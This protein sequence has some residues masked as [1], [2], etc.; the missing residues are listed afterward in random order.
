VS[1]LHAESVR[2]AFTLQ[3]ESFNVSGPATDAP[4]IDAIVELA[5]PAAHERWLEAAC[6]PGLVSRRLAPH[7]AAVSGYDLTP[8]M[9]DVARREAARSGLAN[10]CFALGDATALPEPDGAFDGAVTRFSLHHIPL[11]GRVLAEL[12]RAVAPN[13]RIVI[14]D[15]LLDEDP[16]AAA[17][18]QELERLRDPSHWASLT[19]RRAVALADAAGLV[20]DRE[21]LLPMEL[22]FDDWVRRGAAGDGAQALIEQTVP[23]Q[24]ATAE[25]FV[26]AERD[27][28]RTLRMQMWLARLRRRPVS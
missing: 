10:L 21:L 26:I 17:W 15:P 12:A 14:V 3:A 20:V 22:D 28:R 4:L 25:R 18:S 7:V 8:A 5:A 19:R 6:G 2:A 16:D 24:P 13:G 1:G 11:P 23:Q 27:G 9:I